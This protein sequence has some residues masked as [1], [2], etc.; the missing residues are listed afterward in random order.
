[1]GT[2]ENWNSLV[3]AQQTHK[4]LQFILRSLKIALANTQNV[5]TYD[6]TLHCKNLDR[7]RSHLNCAHYFEETWCD[8]KKVCNKC[9]SLCSVCDCLCE[10]KK[11]L[12]QS[13]V[14]CSCA[15][16]EGGFR[17]RLNEITSNFCVLTSLV[18]TWKRRNDR[19][20]IM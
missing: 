9:E 4:Q 11:S 5:R 16:S 10:A 12:S 14:K 19:L 7:I 17:I 6:R 18:S 3:D 15:N 20:F 2:H 13:A 8:H 1:M